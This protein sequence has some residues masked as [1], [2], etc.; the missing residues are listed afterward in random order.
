MIRDAHPLFRQNQTDLTSSIT[1]SGNTKNAISLND[2]STSSNSSDKSQHDMIATPQPI[3]LSQNWPLSDCGSDFISPQPSLLPRFV[4][5][6]VAKGRMRDCKLQCFF[7]PP[8][9]HK[10]PARLSQTNRKHY[11]GKLRVR[12][13]PTSLLL[14]H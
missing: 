11:R 7:Q 4:R 2:A 8:T 3:W 14:R 1:A 6:K 13:Q 9:T 5:E 10:P 12:D